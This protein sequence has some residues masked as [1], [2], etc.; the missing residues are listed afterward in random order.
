MNPAKKPLGCGNNLVELHFPI[1]R[2]HWKWP[3]KA[4]S[5]VKVGQR[6]IPEALQSI[7]QQIISEFL[8]AIR[9]SVAKETLGG[10]SS[11]MMW[12]IPNQG[13]RIREGFLLLPNARGEPSHQD[14]LKLNCLNV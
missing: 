1:R 13:A 11:A 14:F 10:N 7:V 5:D 12:S 2:A 6:M 8:E 9:P 3:S 4:K